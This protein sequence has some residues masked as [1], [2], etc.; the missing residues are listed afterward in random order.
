MRAQLRNRNSRRTSGATRHPTVVGKL[1]IGTDRPKM[2]PAAVATAST[3]AATAAAAWIGDTLLLRLVIGRKF[4]AIRAVSELR[5]EGDAT[6]AAELVSQLPLATQELINGPRQRAIMPLVALRAQH[7]AD[8]CVEAVDLRLAWLD[9]FRNLKEGAVRLDGTYRGRDYRFA[10]RDYVNSED[11]LVMFAR[12]GGMTALLIRP[13]TFGRLTI[14]EGGAC[15]NVENMRFLGIV[16]LTIRWDG[17]LNDEGDTIHWA[18]SQA[19]IGWRWLGR[20]ISQPPAAERLRQNPWLIR[21]AEGS[22]REH[23]LVLER[24]GVGRLVYAAAEK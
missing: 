10:Y 7:A 9:A 2:L 24:R 21:H 12:R 20:T 15:E 18:S 5:P 14:G 6:I 13:V 11:Q 19:R 4:L 23:L 17:A 16:P 22:E 8:P 3:A 1:G